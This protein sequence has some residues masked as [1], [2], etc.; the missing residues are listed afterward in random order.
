MPEWRI[1]LTGVEHG[2][3]LQAPVLNASMCNH[4]WVMLIK[5]YRNGFRSARVIAFESTQY[6]QI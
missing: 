6:Q 1:W 2:T 5:F 4:N 3:K